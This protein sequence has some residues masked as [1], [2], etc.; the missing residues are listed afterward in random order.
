MSVLFEE[1]WSVVEAFLGDLV[2][3]SV[4]F[5]RIMNAEDRAFV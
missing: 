5:T 4:F 2:G 1:I 3:G